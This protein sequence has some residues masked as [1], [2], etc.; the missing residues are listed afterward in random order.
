MSTGTENAVHSSGRI[1]YNEEFSF[2]RG[3]DIPV[4][5]LVF[6]QISATNMIT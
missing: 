6:D 5:V 4:I 2:D 3:N 1:S